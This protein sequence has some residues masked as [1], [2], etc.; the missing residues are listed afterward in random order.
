MANC[1]DCMNRYSIDGLAF[2][3]RCSLHMT[4]VSVH[5]WCQQHDPQP[6]ATAVSK[7]ELAD[8]LMKPNRRITDNPRSSEDI[9]D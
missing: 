7:I 2:D 9:Y 5:S 4:P 1:G 3:L 8:E 6:S